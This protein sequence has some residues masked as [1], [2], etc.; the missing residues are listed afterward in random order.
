MKK[1]LEGLKGVT[2]V[3]MDV[4]HDLFRLTLAEKE[5]PTQ[6]ALYTVIKDLGYTPSA[7]TP[8]SF[9]TTA[10]HLH[11]TGE[12]PEVVRKALDRAKSEGKKFVLVD[13][14]GDN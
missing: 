14:M 2:K 8:K 4:E 12:A 6:E 3:E 10:K 7:E 11:P 1:A 9:R 5:A 13:C